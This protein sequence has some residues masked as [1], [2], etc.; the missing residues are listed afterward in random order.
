MYLTFGIMEL[1]ARAGKIDFD[2]A[3]A[4]AAA[5]QPSWHYRSPVSLELWRLE[6]DRAVAVTGLEWAEEVGRLPASLEEDDD[7]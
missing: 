6:V 1:S 5:S 4:R 7:A 3:C 2:E